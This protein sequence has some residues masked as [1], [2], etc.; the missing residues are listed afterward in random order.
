M[1]YQEYIDKAKLHEEESKA[2]FTK[3][4]RKKKVDS[5]F[6]D[7]HEEAF[8]EIECLNCANCCKTTSPIFR[9]VDIRRLAKKIKIKDSQFVDDLLRIDSDNDY[10]LQSSPCY[11]LNED[12]T[13]SVYKD[14][15]NACKEYPHTNRKRMSQ[16]LDLTLK[17]AEVCPA[18]AKIV[19]QIRVNEK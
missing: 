9:D 14:R 6:H 2:L 1:E 18:V 10:V 12:N 11:F 17:N 8:E 15:P 19:E 5:Y 7:K 4:K 3:L 16:L 13:C